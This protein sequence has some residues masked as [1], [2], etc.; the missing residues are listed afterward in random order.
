MGQVGLRIL[1]GGLR[2]RQ[3]MPWTRIVGTS[4]E[5]IVESP[6]WE[7]QQYLCDGEDLILSDYKG[8]GAL[9]HAQFSNSRRA[10]L[11]FPSKPETGR[12]SN[13]PRHQF[14]GLTS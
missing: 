8:L 5:G 12:S 3:A 9:P 4:A 14:T 13:L 6:C 11:S 10:G 7:L 1:P 2:S